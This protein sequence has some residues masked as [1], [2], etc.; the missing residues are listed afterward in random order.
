[1]PLIV[2][3]RCNFSGD[4]LVGEKD[5]HLRIDCAPTSD[6]I[7]MTETVRHSIFSIYRNIS[8]CTNVKTDGILLRVLVYCL[9]PGKP[10]FNGSK[11]C[12]RW[13]SKNKVQKQHMIE[14]G[15]YPTS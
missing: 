1:M 14:K 9:D 5:F 10:P 13:N 2:P 6:I 12:F 11:P 3:Y 7:I 8:S 15:T 4:V